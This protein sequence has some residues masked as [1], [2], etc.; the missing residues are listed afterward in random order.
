MKWRPQ[1]VLVFDNSD[2]LWLQFYGARGT[3]QDFAQQMLIAMFLW[4]DTLRVGMCH[5][6][7]NG[8]RKTET[9]LAKKAS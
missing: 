2:F 3:G 7:H 9:D 1:I 8:P 5:I 6:V 4:C